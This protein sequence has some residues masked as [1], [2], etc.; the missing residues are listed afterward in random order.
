[1]IDGHCQGWACHWGIPTPIRNIQY[2]RFSAHL[3]YGKNEIASNAGVNTG[4]SGSKANLHMVIIIIIIIIIIV[5]ITVIIIII[6]HNYI[7]IYIFIPMIFPWYPH[8]FMAQIHGPSPGLPGSTAGWGEP[9]TS[10]GR[11]MPRRP[12][13]PPMVWPSH[14]FSNLSTRWCPIVS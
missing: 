3:L 13:G 8:V 11:K 4:L 1:M 5:I 6:I 10:R 12:L 14:W 9:T 7:Y 2:H